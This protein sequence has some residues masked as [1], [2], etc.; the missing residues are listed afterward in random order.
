MIGILTFW[1]VYNYGA[2]CQAYA[3]N[4]AITSIKPGEEVNHIAYLHE[5]HEDLYFRRH[6]PEY[7]GVR[8]WISPNYYKAKILYKIAPQLKNKRFEQCWNSI[9]HK[10]FSSVQEMEN[11]QIDVLVLGSD[12][13]WEFSTRDFGDDIH[14][15][16]IN[17]N[18]KKKVAYGPSFGDMNLEYFFPEY[19]PKGLN[20]LDYISVRDKTSAEIVTKYTGNRPEIV[21]DPT[22]LWDFKQDVNIPEVKQK[23]YILVYG[24]NF[25]DDFISEIKMYARNNNLKIIG[26]GMAPKWCDK[27]LDDLSP[28]EWIGYFKSADLVVTC[29]FHGLMFAIHYEKKFIFNQIEHVKNRSQYLL[30][31][32]GLDE[33]Y[34]HGPS[35]ERLLDFDWDYDGINARI[36]PIRNKSMEILKEMLS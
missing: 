1:G 34:R 32:A 27:V 17:M 11:Y 6:E 13:I 31:L 3:L 10:S 18:A 14:L 24:C 12:A 8:S 26:V 16:G 35:V 21:L 2:F 29:T 33:V 4:K 25:E 28:L 19:I 30:E 22:F 5:K 7:K 23:N 9:P 20:T 36:M 15:L